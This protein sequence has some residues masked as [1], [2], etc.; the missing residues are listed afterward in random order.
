MKRR[1][2]GKGLS[3]LIPQA[4]VR[5]P[6]TPPTEDLV[7]PLSSVASSI[8]RLAELQIDIDR[9]RPNSQQPRRDFDE[10][11]LAAL[12]KSVGS[13]GMLQP[14]VVRPVDDGRYELIAGERRWRAAQRAGLLK[15]PAIIREVPDERMLEL[16][17]VENLQREELNPLE[18]AQAYRVLVEDLHLTQQ[19]VAERVGKQRATVANSLRL[20]TLAL[21]VQ[22]LVRERGIS[23]GHAKSIAALQDPAAQVRVAERVVKQQLSVRQTEALV[24]AESR[25]RV[26]GSLSVPTRAVVDPNVAAAEER[27]QRALGTKVRIYQG[28]K[29]GRIE[30]DFFS[31]EELERVYQMI[32]K[33]AQIGSSAAD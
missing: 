6:A 32:L 27:L 12:A 21:R 29:R 28:A 26:N 19:E 17:L 22:T 23:A 7:G 30:I 16:A 33:A 1:A 18:E 8:P 2:L 24:A 11:A 13:D 25:N 20:L 14:V 10:A 31:G 15:V 3:S 9:I 5:K 4:P